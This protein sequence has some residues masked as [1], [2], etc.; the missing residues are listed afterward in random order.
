[1]NVIS[2]CPLRVASLEWHTSRGVPV[3][4]V[5]AKATYHLAPVTCSLADEQEDPNEYESHWNDDSE[6]SLHS[7]SDLVPYKPRAE[8]TLVGQTFAP[9]GEP[10]SRLTARLI[11]GGVD[12]SVVV[13]AP[14]SF[15]Q[16]GTLHHGPRF[17]RMPLR[18]ERAAGGLDTANPVGVTRAL[19]TVGAVTLPNLEPPA[20]NV[21]R[22]DD[23]IEP[24][25]FGPIAADWP[26]RRARLGRYAGSWSVSALRTTA[27]PEGIEPAYF[28][29]APADQL[30]DELRANERIVLENLHPDHPRLVTS[31]PGYE[32]RAFVQRPRGP[33]AELA[34]VCDTLWIDT[35]R[36][37]CTLTWRGQLTLE[38]PAEEGRVVVAM[39]M[40]GRPLAWSNVDARGPDAPGPA[41]PAS[42]EAPPS[43]AASRRRHTTAHDATGI[44]PVWP[45]WLASKEGEPTSGSTGEPPRGPLP[46]GDLRLADLAAGGTGTMEA[47]IPRQVIDGAMA[48]AEATRVGPSAPPPPVTPWAAAAPPAPYGGSPV[49]MGL[50]RGPLAALM[51]APPPAPLPTTDRSAYPEIPHGRRPSDAPPPPRVPFYD[52]MG[53]AG[54]LP[55]ASGR[56][57][58]PRPPQPA[59]PD[60]RAATERGAGAASNAAAATARTSARPAD[61]PGA[62]PVAAP[63]RE[64][65]REHIDLLWFDP[66]SLPRILADEV[67]GQGRAERPAVRWVKEAAAPREPQEARD[68]RE[69]LGIFGRGKPVDEPAALDRVAT[70]AYRDDGTF[71]PP[72][73]L[74][75]GELSFD[76]DE[77]E[78]LR[79]TLTVITPFLGA[80]KKLRDVAGG[81][82]DALKT[83]GRLP[84]DIAAGLTRRIEEAFAQGQRSVAPGYLDTSVER[85]LLEDR[86]Y[87]KRTLFGEP[88]LRARLAFPPGGPA[89]SPAGG[90]AGGPTGGSGTPLPT[91]LPEALAN[92]LPLFRRFKVRAIVELRP[93]EDQYE[94]H[95][96]ALLVLALGRVLRRGGGLDR[97][98]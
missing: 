91:Y 51:A 49:A 8:V 4:T 54:G 93:Q 89:G 16:D 32:P 23:Y 68:H 29:S 33:V 35:D 18:Y 7:P 5:V 62:L 70:S 19:D 28:L 41:Q 61:R 46:S 77:V 76:F 67:L 2:V 43:P 30:L 73:V 74:V 84:G 94:T 25:G 66:A 83:E 78:T 13:H 47:S 52:A 15:S 71:A 14:R 86:R 22:P 95:A 97:G 87:A 85:I 20:L 9:R 31:L 11:V 36:S 17:G 48:R 42:V 26:A 63:V 55:Q 92:R 6:R 82:T 34:M 57:S 56:Q 21:T 12:K 75:A 64:P 37:M 40:I 45:A 59:V 10:V 3:L 65:P 60:L 53:P 39:E 69:L 88:R 80:D 79:A 90:A 27:L 72:L 44:A 38:G 24:V 50:G 58:S 98:G 1:M 81:A 96:D